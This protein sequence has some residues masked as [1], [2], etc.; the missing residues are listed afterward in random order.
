[1]VPESVSQKLRFARVRLA[2]LSVLIQNNR[3]AA[4]R[5]A[6]HQLTQEFFFHVVGA[7]EYL[8]Q[9]VNE[10]R[11]LSLRAENVAVYKVAR[12]IEKRDPADPLLAPLSGLSAD[13]RKTPLPPD[14]YSN[15]GLVYRTANYRNEVAHRNTN[16][17]HF[18]LSAGPMV[19]FL[20]LDPRDHS[21]GRSARSVDADLSSMVATIDRGCRTVLGLLQ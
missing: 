8:A 18:V 6:R 16:P 15:E 21:L 11:A 4:D 5:D 3:L 17:F 13:T 7:T 12:E 2:D 10:R 1:M 14:P 9:P 19:A 20:W